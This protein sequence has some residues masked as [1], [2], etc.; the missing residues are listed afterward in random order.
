MNKCACVVVRTSA[1]DDKKNYLYIFF[2]V[3]VV[4]DDCLHLNPIG[5]VCVPVH[6]MYYANQQTTAK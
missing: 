2:V 5:I 6:N 3:F 4:R 1:Y